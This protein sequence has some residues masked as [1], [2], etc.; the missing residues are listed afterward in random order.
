VSFFMSKGM[1]LLWYRK[2]NMAFHKFRKLTGRLSFVSP[3]ASAKKTCSL[4][5]LPYTMLDKYNIFTYPQS[6][7][8]NMQIMN[9]LNINEL[10]D[11]EISSSHGGE[12]DVQSC[13]LGCTAV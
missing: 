3:K 10:K 6:R 1:T 12:Y 7:I 8:L 11:C 4:N 9:F 5:L 2:F 13:L